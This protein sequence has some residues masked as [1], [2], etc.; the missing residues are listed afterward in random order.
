MVNGPDFTTTGGTSVLTFTSFAT[1]ATR[2]GLSSTQIAQMRHDIVSLVQRYYAPFDINIVEVT[3]ATAFRAAASLDDIVATLAFNNA[4]TERNDAY[5]LIA[6]ITSGGMSLGGG[7]L[8]GQAGGNDLSS[9]NLADDTA[10][11]L[12]NNLFTNG[13]ANLAQGDTAFA[14][15]IAHEAGHTFGLEHTV[16]AFAASAN[17][18]LLDRS[19]MMA[20]FY[21]VAG[22]RSPGADQRANFN[23]FTRFGLATV[24]GTPLTQNAFDDLASDPLIGL[25]AGTPA[26]VTGTGAFDRIT[27]MRLDATHA[28]VTVEAF[29]DATFGD[30]QQIGADYTYDIDTTNGILVEGGYSDDRIV[31]DALLAAMVTV[32]GMAGNDQ[33]VVLGNGATIGSYLPN[34][35]SEAGLD[36]RTS[37]G[38]YITAGSTRIFVEEFELAGSVTAQNFA[39]FTFITP[40]SNDFVTLESPES[41]RDRIFGQS[42]GVGLVPLAATSVRNLVLEVGSHD[43]LSPIDTVNV[44]GAATGIGVTINLGVGDDV[45]NVGNANRLDPI[46]GPL[47]VNG[48]GGNDQVRLSDYSGTVGVGYTLRSGSIDRGALRLLTYATLENITLEGGAGSDKFQVTGTATG[49]PV[50]IDGGLGVDQLTGPNV[51]TAWT[52]NAANAGTFTGVTFRSMEALVGGTA[53]DDFFF[54]G[55]EGV[56]QSV[57]GGGGTDTLNYGLYG[58][59]VNVNLA[60]GAATGIAARAVSRVFSIENVSGSPYNDIIVGS[61]AANRLFGG[62]GRDLL[63]GG[64]GSDSLDGGTD[65]DLLIA[66]TTDYDTHDAALLAIMTEWT[67]RDISYLARIGHL[68]AGSG[69][70]GGARLTAT[71]V[72]DD[73]AADALL[74]G[75]GLDWFW[76]VAPDTSDRTTD[77][78]ALTGALLVEQIN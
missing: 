49:V 23:F 78:D 8:N 57:N 56:D 14:W 58:S 7:T 70:T 24:D 73:G 59:G 62:G 40:N 42:D 15:T 37:F 39:A 9:T 72:H 18:I 51:Y 52:I 36:G 53:R 64:L 38:G 33:L 43:E 69:L 1:E 13:S 32:R 50:S 6:G 61:A 16:M 76:G 5:L 20:Q 17:N 35:G 11:V 22:A 41:G 66:G 68:R 48:Q 65:E 47:T 27:I 25:R 3:A 77:R 30:I 67:R 4:E 63:V 29:R 71:T 74:G 54:V 12:A 10:V 60:T 55:A 44:V 75:T 26:Y 45:V 31:V 19:D 46:L 28:T 21:N 2:A 34:G